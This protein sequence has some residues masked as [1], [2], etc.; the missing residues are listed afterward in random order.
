MKFCGLDEF[1][2][3]ED[4][5][6]NEVEGLDFEEIN[7]RL[8]NEDEVKKYRFL[9]NDIAYKFYKMYGMKK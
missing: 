3:S 9:N 4:E 2:G 6:V 5:N 7:F 8:L 1:N